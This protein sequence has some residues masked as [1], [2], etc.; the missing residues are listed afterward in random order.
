MFVF[1][2]EEVGRALSL[3]GTVFSSHAD[4]CEPVSL[5]SS[6]THCSRLTYSSFASSFLLEA[7]GCRDLRYRNFEDFFEIT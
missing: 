2:Q 4:L 7:N 5:S 6:I 3:P 1:V